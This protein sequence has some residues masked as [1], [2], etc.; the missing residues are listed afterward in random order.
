[1]NIRMA[2]G[3]VS[4]KFSFHKDI[5]IMN[6]TAECPEGFIV[7]PLRIFVGNRVDDIIMVL[8]IKKMHMRAKMSFTTDIFLQVVAF[9]SYN[10][11]P[12]KA[13]I[14]KVIT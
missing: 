6:E 3:T 11:P 4:R 5:N 12:E 8:M 10:T 1:M 9:E 14:A 2:H 7:Y 13:K